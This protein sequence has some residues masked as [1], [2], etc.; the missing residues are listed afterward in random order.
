LDQRRVRSRASIS[1]RNPQR[2]LGTLATTIVFYGLPNVGFTAE[3]GGFSGTLATDF[4]RARL[5]RA[6]GSAVPRASTVT[7]NSDIVQRYDAF[8]FAA[9][10]RFPIPAMDQFMSAY[11]F[12]VSPAEAS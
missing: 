7:S 4:F 10:P 11:F 5:E 2:R 9:G 8:T 6:M 12:P 3:L 1:Q